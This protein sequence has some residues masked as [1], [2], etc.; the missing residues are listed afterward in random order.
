MET[1]SETRREY[2]AQAKP[3][4]DGIC[5]RCGHSYFDCRG[6]CTCLSCNLQRQSEIT[7]GLW[8]ADD[9][10]DEKELI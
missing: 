5:V 9:P 8:F 4:W 3:E 6:N 2:Y 7:D 1:K 10:E